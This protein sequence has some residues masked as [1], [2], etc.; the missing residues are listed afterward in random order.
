MSD[1]AQ[2]A[3]AP[4]RI[5]A[6]RAGT[7]G[8]CQ[9]GVLSVTA[10][11][12]RAEIVVAGTSNGVSWEADQLVQEEQ[13]VLAAGTAF[14]VSAISPPAGSDQGAV[15]FNPAGRIEAWAGAVV[16]SQDGT[17]RVDGPDVAAATDMQAT[18]W[19]DGSVDVVT[20]PARSL[21][22][23][24]EPD[25]VRTLHLSVGAKVAFGKSEAAVLAVEPAAPGHAARAV[26]R[27]SPRS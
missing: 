12:L 23:N 15:L 19:H 17:L 21:R 24:A 4:V 5:A 25:S 9:V 18:A 26:I 10:A 13:T 2:A 11:P 22:E 14:Q 1:S 7:L 27:L 16:L 20:W 8:P 6:T 3:D